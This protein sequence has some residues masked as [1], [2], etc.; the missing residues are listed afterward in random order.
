[1]CGDRPKKGASIREE[2]VLGNI[3]EAAHRGRIQRAIEG[4]GTTAFRPA[5]PDLVYTGHSSCRRTGTLLYKNCLTPSPFLTISDRKQRPTATKNYVDLGLRTAG[6]ES[7]KL[8]IMGQL[9]HPVL[10]FLRNAAFK[11]MPS[12]VAMKLI[13]QYFSYRVTRIAI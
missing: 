4:I 9:E 6:G 12:R 1:M 2:R 10:V 3:R 13:D 5:K 8:G 11:R 7:L